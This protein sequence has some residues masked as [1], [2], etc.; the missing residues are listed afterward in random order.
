MLMVV[1]LILKAII[2]IVYYNYVSFYKVMAGPHVGDKEKGDGHGGKSRIS[3]IKSC[4][5]PTVGGP[6]AWTLRDA[7]F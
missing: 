4:M 3:S 7:N 2:C 6:P 5:Q 1:I